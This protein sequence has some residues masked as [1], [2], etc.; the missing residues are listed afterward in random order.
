MK[1]AIIISILFLGIASITSSC[2]KQN[3]TKDQWI[4]SQATDLEDGTDITSD[5]TDE[6]WEY[7]KDGT[8]KE[9]GTVKGTWAFSDGKE[10]LIITKLD[11]STDTYKI[12]KLKKKEMWIEELGQEE[13]HLTKY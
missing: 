8:Y 5:F 4:I 7:D 12:L 3:L 11:N 10:D 9:N 1:R 6:I 2:K 13:L